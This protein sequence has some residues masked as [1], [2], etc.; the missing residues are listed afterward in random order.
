MRRFI[1]AGNWK[2]NH[3]LT[4]G[5][6]LVDAIL[7]ALDGTEIPKNVDIVVCP[8]YP[9]LGKASMLLDGNTVKLGAQNMHQEPEG[10]YTGEVSA[11]MLLSVGC[12][13]VILGHSERRQYFKESDALVNKKLHAALKAGLKPIVC[14]GETLTQRESGSTQ[15]VV[16]EQVRGALDDITAQDM[17]NVIIAYEPVWAIGT[18]KTATPEQAQEVHRMIRGLLGSLYSET[19]AEFVRIQYGGSMKPANAEELLRQPDVDGGLIGG[20]CLKSE[21]FVSML[22]IASNIARESS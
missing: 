14:V 6:A 4:T 22:E 9:V 11:N 7:N 10:A 3:D 20:A 18:G 12:E 21:S 15:Q 19:I 13:Y 8:P 2:M 17:R 16:E 5:G 1:L